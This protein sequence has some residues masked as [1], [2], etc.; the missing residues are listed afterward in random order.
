MLNNLAVT[1]ASVIA[2]IVTISL[3]VQAQVAFTPITPGTL[4]LAPGSFDTLESQT[5]VTI[6][7]QSDRPVTLLVSPPH[8]VSGPT[9]DPDG[10]IL[11][12]VVSFGST[13][14][15]SDFGNSLVSIPPGSTDL[16]IDLRVKRPTP[17]MVGTYNYAVTLTVM[18]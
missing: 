4:D 18:P 16:E 10:T 3:P 17:F 13:R 1:L 7:V 8:L 14:V 6:R 12:G 2:S 5:P 9:P 11:A 15:S